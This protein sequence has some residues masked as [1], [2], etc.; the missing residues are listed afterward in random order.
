[1]TRASLLATIAV[2]LLVPSGAGAQVSVRGFADAGL[3]VF[4]ATQSFKAILGKASGP[5]YGGGIEF[6]ERGFF[7]SIG[8]ERF[9]RAGHRLFV[10]DNQVFTLNVKDTITVTPVDLTFGY[11]LRSHG[12]VP[13]AGGG[14][15]WYRYQEISEHATDAE[16]VKQT[17]TGYHVLGGVEVPIQ[18]WLAAGLDAKWSTV[19]NAFGDS[20]T[21]VAS[22]Y[23]EHNIGGF[24]LRAKIIVGR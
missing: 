15:G 17:S 19:P 12:I 6:G 23:N 9:R 18:K 4:S 3:T 1:M 21:G 20:T 14:V 24:T 2:L 10:F 22:V 13:Y 16:D 5:V 7:L 8:A 11:R